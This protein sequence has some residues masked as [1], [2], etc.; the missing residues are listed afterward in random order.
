MPE[1][2]TTWMTAEVI[3]A[4]EYIQVQCGRETEELDERVAPLLH[5]D[6][7]DSLNC[8]EASVLLSHRLGVTVEHRVFATSRGQPLSCAEIA[9]TIVAQHGS[10]LARPADEAA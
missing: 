8:M 2:I 9:R 5:L 1:D 4:V 6:G 3:R 10:G 7:F